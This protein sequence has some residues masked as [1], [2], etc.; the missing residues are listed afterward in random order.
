MT[1]FRAPQQLFD[2]S[3]FEAVLST[4]QLKIAPPDVEMKVLGESEENETLDEVEVF[5][6]E[7][8]NRSFF[9]RI[10]ESAKHTEEGRKMAL[11][12]GTQIWL[13][14]RLTPEVVAFLVRSTPVKMLWAY[15]TH[16]NRK[17]LLQTATRGF[18]RTPQIVK[19]PVV[20]SRLLK[21]FEGHSE[22]T[23]ILLVMWSFQEPQ[24]PVISMA[25]AEPDEA[26]LKAKL[27]SL[28]KK[29]GVEATLAGL[30]VAARPRAYRAALEIIA[31]KD[32]LSRLMQDDA[33]EDE[34]PPHIEPPADV[35]AAPEPDSPA[36]H[37]WKEK[38]EASDQEW[39]TQ[40]ETLG[41]L[42]D[43]A[44]KS[45]AQIVTQKAEIDLLQKREIAN[46][47]QWSNKLEH[48]QKRLQTELDELRKTFERQGRKFRALERE[49]TDFE[50]ENRRLKKQLR[51]T[52]QLLEEERRKVAAL[53]AK[54]G[55]GETPS[56]PVKAL[57][58]PSVS[59]SAP[60]KPIVV[61]SPTPLDEIF[62]WRAD[63]RPV[64]ITP[65]AVRRLI[66]AN[67]EDAIFPIMQA[68]EALRSSDRSMHGKFLKRLSEAGN[69]YSRVLTE[70]MTRVLVDASNVARHSP[71]RYGKGQLR[72]L[73]EM[74]DELRR[75]DCFPIIFVADASLP[76]FIDE[77][78]KFREMV[79]R[80]EITMAN[81]GTEADEILAREARRTG[82][83]VVTNDAKFFHKV[84]PD[85][86]PPRITFRIYDGTV[87]VDGF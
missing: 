70:S 30:C 61:Q 28:I 77:A 13:T 68:L 84:S 66:D 45:S 52:G 11:V 10:P 55:R 60:N 27:S 59:Q 9:E 32:E 43:R 74:R 46:A 65:R 37:Y 31:D 85:F 56:A 41:N 4:P 86:E 1:E 71:N 17:E 24:C 79:M 18:Q 49:K 62:E 64:K 44:E 3:F 54:S 21:W 23:Y 81:K 8:Y 14:K 38:F 57:T 35:E 29:F 51:H 80:G 16:E 83:Y 40:L 75:L 5:D 39:R 6:W 19:Q 53:E 20:R 67:D 25:H 36:A 50:T 69:Y 63:G 33:E 15:L 87:I 76:Y 26:V 47:K 73:L 2:G 58:T 12:A 82:A 78:T 72:H 7:E 22:E 34:D 42:R 48:V